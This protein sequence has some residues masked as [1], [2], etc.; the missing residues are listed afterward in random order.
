MQ[1]FACIGTVYVHVHVSMTLYFARA[2]AQ[3]MYIHV[4]VHLRLSVLAPVSSP[5]PSKHQVNYVTSH[6]GP[7]LT[8]AFSRDGKLAA[9]G[10]ADSSIK[11]G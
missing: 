11:V 8:A 6:K 3:C 2:Y 10:S 4:Y 1:N 5:C 7:C 9:S